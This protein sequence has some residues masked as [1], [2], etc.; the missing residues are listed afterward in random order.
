[1]AGLRTWTIYSCPEQGCDVIGTTPH[2]HYACSMRGHKP[3]AA[4]RVTPLT[5]AITEALAR[6]EGAAHRARTTDPATSHAAAEDTRVTRENQRGRIVAACAR[7]IADVNTIRAAAGR[8]LP[9]AEQLTEY[10]GIPLNSVSTRLSELCDAGYLRVAD[11]HGRTAAGHRASR[12]DV[13]EKG[14]RW[15]VAAP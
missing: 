12:Y 2:Q 15:L 5:R 13:T 7:W 10:T 11:D 9:T 8:T 6:A 1:V 14:N 4:V 3:P